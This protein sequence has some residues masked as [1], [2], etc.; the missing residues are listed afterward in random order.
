M[1]QVRFK[2]LM[3][4]AV[5]ALVLYQQIYSDGRKELFL[6]SLVELAKV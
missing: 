1:K 3:F 6:T 5:N 2:M 4:A